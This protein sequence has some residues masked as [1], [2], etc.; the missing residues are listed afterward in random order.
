MASKKKELKLTR[1][2]D[3]HYEFPVSAWRWRSDDEFQENI[4]P[5]TLRG[6]R[7]VRLSHR[8]QSLAQCAFELYRSLSRL[9]EALDRLRSMIAEGRSGINFPIANGAALEI[10]CDGE[11]LLLYQRRLGLS[12]D[13]YGFLHGK[14]AF[15]RDGKPVSEMADFRA[16]E[17]LVKDTDELV[18]G[19]YKAEKDGEDFLIKLIDMPIELAEDFYLARDCFSV[20]LDEIGLLLAGRALEGVVRRIMQDRHVL[21]QSRRGCDPAS[22]SDLNDIIEVARRL[23]WQKGKS[24]A[25]PSDAIQ[26]LHWQREVRNA[27]AHPAVHRGYTDPRTLALAVVELAG[28]LWKVHQ[29]KSRAR[30]QTSVIVKDW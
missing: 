14:E 27:G 23:R 11:R 30:L 2:P 12:M 16:L 29:S 9:T 19:F 7:N 13:A 6:V 17:Q 21:L 18:C 25:F 10:C 4:S 20:G 28:Q 3:E 24:R 15:E 5:F 26:L 1:R 22:E 8:S